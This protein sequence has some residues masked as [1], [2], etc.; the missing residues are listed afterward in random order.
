MAEPDDLA[1]PPASLRVNDRVAI[2]RAELVARAS[3][4]GGAGGQG[5]NKVSSRVEVVWSVRDS[6]ALTDDERAR[7]IERLAS[8]LDGEGHLR[9]VASDMRSQ[10]QNRELAEDR[11]AS[12]VAR[13]LVVPKKRRPTK[14]P[15]AQKE[16]RLAEKKLRSSR[17]RDRRGGFDE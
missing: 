1:P 16:A 8:K 6:A 7:V 13:A 10:H 2:P 12:L 4:S 14:V 5:V 9:V 3:R 15:R 11:L 17:K